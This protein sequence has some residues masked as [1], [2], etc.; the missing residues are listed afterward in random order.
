VTRIEPASDGFL[1]VTMTPLVRWKGGL[2]DPVPVRTGPNKASCG[3]TFE[4]GRE[5]LVFADWAVL[6]GQDLYYT[7]SCSRTRFAEGN[8]DIEQLGPPLLPT[9]A[10]TISWGGVKVA[11]R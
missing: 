3:V 2:V 7:T 9:T 6:F 8:P 11:W 4:V 10:R 1:I 5:Y